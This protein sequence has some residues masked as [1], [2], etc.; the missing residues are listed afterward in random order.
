MHNLKV[1]NYVLYCNSLRTSEQSITAIWEAAS[2]AWRG[3]EGARVYRSF[4]TKPSSWNIKRLLL[5]K[6]N[7][8]S[9][10]NEFSTVLCIRSYKSL[11]SLKSLLWYV[12]QL[13]EASILCF[14]ILSLCWVPL[15]WMMAR[16]WVLGFHPEFPQGPPQGTTIMQRLD[17]WNILC[18]LPLA[19]K[20]FILNYM[21]FQ[22]E[23]LYIYCLLPYLFIAVTQSSLRGCHIGY[24]CSVRPPNKTETHCIYIVVFYCLLPQLPRGHLPTEQLLLILQNNSVCQKEALG[25]PG[26]DH[27]WTSSTTKGLREKINSLKETPDLIQQ[28]M[29]ERWQVVWSSKTR[30]GHTDQLPGPGPERTLTE[31][32]LPHPQSCCSQPRG[33]TLRCTCAPS[34][35]NK[36]CPRVLRTPKT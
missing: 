3:K 12:P 14:P 23:R 31:P 5:I 27:R 29:D 18:L 20:F 35:Q 9:Q 33:E 17:G 30:P 11:G 34:S 26:L 22:G 1:G 6:E 28:N 8:T 36:Q 7:Q 16:W 2:W 13:S 19:D 21:Y 15:Q 32:Q 10:V 25:F 24:K 4:V